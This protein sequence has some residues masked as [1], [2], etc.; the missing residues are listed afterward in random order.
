MRSIIATA[1]AVP[2]LSG[3]LGG[4]VGCR[5]AQP[6]ALV[7]GELRERVG[8]GFATER[9]DDAPPALPAEVRLDDGVSAD[10]AVAIALWNSATFRIELTRLHAAEAEL[11]AAKRPSN[12]TLRLLFPA[13]PQQLSVLLTWPIEN[14]VTMPR[15][16][17]VA[18]TNLDVVAA[19]VVQIGVDLARDVKLAH[20]DWALAHDRLAVRGSLAAD[21]AAIATIVRARANGGDVPVTEAEIAE[22][23]A[24]LAS[25]EV[26]RA[27]DEV[28]IAGSRLEARLGGVSLRA[29]NPSAMA[30]ATIAAHASSAGEAWAASARDTRPDL[31]AAQL[32]L[33][34]A[35]ARVGLERAAVL[36][37]AGVGYGVG[38]A[39]T[40]GVQGELPIASQNQ[41]GVGRARAQL[42]AARWRVVEL[43]QRVDAEVTQARTQLD[44]ALRSWRLY[45]D[46]VVAARTRDLAAA[47][48]QYDLGESDYAAVLLSAQRLETTRLRMIELAA[49]VRRAH[50]E[51]E[52][53]VG[54]RLGAS[55]PSTKESR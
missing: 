38:P 6:E 45:D 1:L 48:A 7:E 36:N 18:R 16:I 42:E 46:E 37:L 32:A 17:K 40:G 39:F 34:T 30:P 22:A 43:R 41:L 4:V 47:T 31:R 49:D 24:R 44:G 13:G 25:D 15:R 55:P 9:G 50:A 11:A 53:A 14:L 51:L 5:H 54:R 21:F 23:D 10:E 29:A 3:T 26:A 19:Q 20:A 2:L 8:H 28:A 35:G 33:E 27:R 52:R 12:P